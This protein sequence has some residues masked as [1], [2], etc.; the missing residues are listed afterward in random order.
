MNEKMNKIKRARNSLS[1]TP[2]WMFPLIKGK[3]KKMISLYYG[4]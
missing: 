3:L 1:E 2:G 4:I